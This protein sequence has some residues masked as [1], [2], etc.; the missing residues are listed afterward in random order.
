MEEK[1]KYQLFV[2]HGNHEH[3][4]PC[5]KSKIVERKR[6]KIPVGKPLT[7]PKAGWEEPPRLLAKHKQDRRIRIWRLFSCGSK[8]CVFLAS[9]GLKLG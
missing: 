5:A 1:V 6:K 9:G 4:S 2:L 3:T 7:Q 8:R